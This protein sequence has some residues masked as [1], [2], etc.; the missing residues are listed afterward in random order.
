M[1]PLCYWMADGGCWFPRFVRIVREVR[2]RIAS[3]LQGNSGGGAD[4]RCRLVSEWGTPNGLESGANSRGTLASPEMS[5]GRIGW[6][7]LGELASATR[8]EVPLVNPVCKQTGT[9][10]K[11]TCNAQANKEGVRAWRSS[12]GR[13]CARDRRR[14]HGRRGRDGRIRLRRS[15]SFR[16]ARRGVWRRSASRVRAIARRKRPLR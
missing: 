14:G 3:C 15:S 8:G 6:R 10:G 7:M 13:T 5:D 12:W 11:E 16:I 2:G 4:Y 9:P 1:G